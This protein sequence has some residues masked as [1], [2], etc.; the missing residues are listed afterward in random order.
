M[1]NSTWVDAASSVGE[2]DSFFDQAVA[3]GLRDRGW[4]VV[5]QIGVSRFRIGLGVAHPDR[6][7]NCLIGIECDGA[8]YHGAATAPA[9]GRRFARRC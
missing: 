4:T 9:I 5:P 6:P 1:K 7:G 8:S 2:A 3:R